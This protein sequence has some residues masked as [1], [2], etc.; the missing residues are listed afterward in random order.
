MVTLN[1]TINYSNTGTEV[2][3]ACEEY[4]WHGSTYTAS[5]NTPTYTE[6]N[7]VGCDS[8]VTLNLTVNY[9]THNSYNQS[10][11]DVYTWHGVDYTESGV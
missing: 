11:C 5:T 7:A 6:Q 8:V 10:A 4:T 3:T 2:Q 1:L 9:G